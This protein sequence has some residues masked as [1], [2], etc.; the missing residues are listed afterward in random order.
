MPKS[1]WAPWASPRFKVSRRE[2][3]LIS[4]RSVAVMPWSA[5]RPF[6]SATMSGAAS[7]SGRKAK[8]SWAFSGAPLSR[9]RPETLRD[10]EPEAVV[11]ST[12]DAARP[13]AS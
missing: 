4:R 12:P 9:R 11:D 5:K 1:I 13:E 6:A 7:V 10:G 8:V 2:V 3:Q